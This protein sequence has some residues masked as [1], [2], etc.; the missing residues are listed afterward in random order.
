MSKRVL[1]MYI[2]YNSGHHRASIAIEKALKM[3]RPDTE[4]LNINGFNYT[5]PILERVINRTYMAVIKRKPQVWDYLYDNPKIFA[6]TQALRD[7]LHNM[8]FDKLLSLLSDFKPDAIVCTQA[9]PCG[10]IADLK[11]R[12]GF[13][14]TPLFGVLTDY[15]PHSYWVFQTIDYFI[16]PAKESKLRLEQNGIASEKIK[17]FGIPID[18]KFNRKADVKFIKLGLG[19]ELDK[20]VVLVMGGGQ[21]YGPIKD[22]ISALDGLDLDFQIIAVAGINGRLFKWL[23]SRKRK[24]NR[25]VAPL[26]FV[27]NVDELMSASDVIITKPGGLTTAEALAKGLPMI[28]VNPIPGQEAK[29][30]QFLVGSGAAIEVDDL[31]IVGNSASELLSNAL[32]LKQMKEAAQNNGHLDAAMNS[33][34]L[35]LEVSD[36]CADNPLETFSFKNASI[37]SL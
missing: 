23:N 21:G 35:I 27:E 7:F 28:I 13:I 2:S 29:N 12:N 25:K 34:K 20:P 15:Y 17:V 9:F 16:V 26:Q 5:N 6:K 30:A 14:K 32:R 22:I 33:A 24:F 31:N 1:L 11:S 4:V 36:R 19:L 18:P 8:N 10:M 3:L 37:P